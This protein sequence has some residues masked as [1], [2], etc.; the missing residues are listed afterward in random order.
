M[1]TLNVYVAFI[2]QTPFSIETLYCIRC[3]IN[4]GPIIMLFFSQVELQI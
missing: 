3:F 2:V 1:E 4:A